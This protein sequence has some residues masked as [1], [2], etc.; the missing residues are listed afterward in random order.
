MINEHQQFIPNQFKLM[1]KTEQNMVN[2]SQSPEETGDIIHQHVHLLATS[3]H[4]Q[5]IDKYANNQWVKLEFHVNTSAISL[6]GLQ[7]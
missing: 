5:N 2:V 3:N 6:D 4:H 7:Q 1:G